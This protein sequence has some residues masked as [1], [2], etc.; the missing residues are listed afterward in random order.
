SEQ[1]LLLVVAY[2]DGLVDDGAPLARVRAATAGQ[3]DVAEVV[4]A[5]LSEEAVEGIVRE[6][7]GTVPAERL[8][9]WLHDLSDGTPFF[10]DQYLS[11]LEAQ[12]VLRRDDGAWVL[13]GT[14]EG[15]PGS[16]TLTGALA[17]VETPAGL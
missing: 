8:P 11:A 12:N 1:A 15:G 13:D 10:I 5:E 14:I 7:Y 6:R 17:H 4:L 3:P 9:A 2:D 16:W